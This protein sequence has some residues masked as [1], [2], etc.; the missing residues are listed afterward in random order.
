MSEIRLLTIFCIFR[1]AFRAVFYDLILL[2]S[3]VLVYYNVCF[4][5]CRTL[6]FLLF[7]A[8]FCM[9]WTKRFAR[10]PIENLV[11]F[12]TK[13]K[14]IEEKYIIFWPLS[15]QKFILRWSYVVLYQ[16]LV[17]QNHNSPRWYHLENFCS[18]LV[19]KIRHNCLTICNL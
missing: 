7:N 3:P 16:D 14:Q 17:I 11:S 9:I 15:N 13:V 6:P 5:L 19:L 1:T 4:P 18:N 8:D 12:V 10:N 2:I